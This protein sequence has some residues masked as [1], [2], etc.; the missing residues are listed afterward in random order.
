M[1]DANITN[2]K[3]RSAGPKLEHIRESVTGVR[4]EAARQTERMR[5]I[6]DGL[7]AMDVNLTLI[8]GNLKRIDQ[9][10]SNMQLNMNKMAISLQVHTSL[11]QEYKRRTESLEKTTKEVHLFR[12]QAIGIVAVIT[13]LAAYLAHLLP[14]LN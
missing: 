1:N 3:L 5:S 9:N 8:D 7:A 12:W 11:L 10:M 14:G 4:I 2:D 13:I 6:K